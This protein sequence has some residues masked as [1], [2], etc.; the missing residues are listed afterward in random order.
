MVAAAGA[1]I[2]R[3]ITDVGNGLYFGYRMTTKLAPGDRVRIEF[4]PLPPDFPLGNHLG[5]DCE[6]CPPFTPLSA[7]LVRYPAAQTVED[8][9]AFTLELLRNS[10]TGESLSDFVRV[11]LPKPEER[12]PESVTR[13]PTKSAPGDRFRVDLV[14]RWDA[15][16]PEVLV[17]DVHVVDLRTLKEM[18]ATRL[19]LAHPEDK[20]LLRFGGRTEADVPFDALVQVQAS[21]SLGTVVYT[22]EV[23]EG[24]DLVHAERV[25]LPYPRR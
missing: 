1:T 19:P 14:L 11:R 21:R 5:E 13:V 4:G 17:A 12:L 15:S 22:I 9:G 25:S 24:E 3:V 2:D 18:N 7:A 23:R 20:G 8:G 16:G 6:R 10:K